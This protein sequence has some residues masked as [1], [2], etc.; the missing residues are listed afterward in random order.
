MKI[1]FTVVTFILASAIQVSSEAIPVNT[2][3]GSL[4]GTQADGGLRSP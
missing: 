1:K 4:L 3:S 2:T